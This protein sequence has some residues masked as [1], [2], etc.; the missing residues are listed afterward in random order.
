[1][2]PFRTEI[3]KG[4][5]AK[6]YFDPEPPNPRTEWDNVGTMVCFHKKYIL[7]DKTKVTKEEL[8][9]LVKRDDVLALPLYLYDHGGL[10]MRT[11]KF[12]QDSGGWDTSMVGYIYMEYSTILKE[13]TVQ[14][15]PPELLD[16]ARGMLESEVQTYDDYLTGQ[17]FS[18]RIESPYGEEIHKDWGFFGDD[19]EKEMKSQYEFMID[20]TIEMDTISTAEVRAIEWGDCE[21]ET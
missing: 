18:Y 17:V 7:G 9:E 19:G 10:A 8:R 4:Y 14:E 1:M 12:P 21:M 11:G 15:I 6:I 3:Y 2:E 13:L 20:S 16:R 5:I